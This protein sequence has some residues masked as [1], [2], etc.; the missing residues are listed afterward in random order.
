MVEPTTTVVIETLKLFGPK[1]FKWLKTKAVGRTLLVVGPA[2]AGKTSYVRYLRTQVLQREGYLPRT[3]DVEK[4][5]S[6][7]IKVGPTGQLYL[8]AKYMRDTPGEAS[9]ATVVKYVLRYKPHALVIVLDLRGEEYERSRKWLEDFCAKMVEKTTVKT[10]KVLRTQKRMRYIQILTNKIDKVKKKKAA[11]RKD[12]VQGIARDEL[13]KV[14][15]GVGANIF[16]FPTVLVNPPNR[17]DL[18]K[19]AIVNLSW[20]L[21]GQRNL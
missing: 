18:I 20:A 16:A 14:Y 21:M 7:L 15:A 13:V 12:K 19:N 6:F 10:R 17:E 2:E 11:E 4:S 1:A 5:P 8:D 3:E 9:I